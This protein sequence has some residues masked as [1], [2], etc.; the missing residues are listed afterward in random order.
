[1]R[2]LGLERGRRRADQARPGRRR[3]RPSSSGSRWPSSRR[4]PAGA[5]EV[6]S[7]TGAGLDDA[8]RRARRRAGAA[9]SRAAGRAGAAADRPRVHAARDRHGRHRHPLV[10]H[11]ARRRRGWRSSRA[12]ASVRVRSVQVHDRP[13]DAAGAGQRVA[14]ALVGAERPEA[15]RG[16]DAGARRALLPRTYRL[17]CRLRGAGRPRPRPCATASVVTVHHGTAETPATRGRARGPASCRRAPR[18]MSSCARAGRV[19]AL[20]AT[21]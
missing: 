19:A 1:M 11:G 16:H 3:A 15:R 5:I 14:L 13:V 9:R 10:G 8:A 2:L 4:R 20:P 21:A 12:G 7:R 6:S 17:E 18:A